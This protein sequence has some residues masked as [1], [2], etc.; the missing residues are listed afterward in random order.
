MLGRRNC[1][2]FLTGTFTLS[3]INPVFQGGL[4]PEVPE[5]LKAAGC[6]VPAAGQCPIIPLFL[7]AEELQPLVP[8]PTRTFN[9][10]DGKFQGKVN[11]R[12]EE[13]LKLLGKYLELPT[14][15]ALTEWVFDHTILAPKIRD[16]VIAYIK[17]ELARKNL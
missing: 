12:V 10:D 7:S 13:L 3:K 6:P 5:K 1:Q 11:E 16:K 2:A 9:P 4:V 14:V 17:S 15:A 8:W